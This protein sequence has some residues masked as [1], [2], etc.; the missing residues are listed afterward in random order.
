MKFWISLLFVFLLPVLLFAQN[1][2]LISEI[3]VDPTDQEFIEIFNPN[4]YSLALDN[5]YLSDYN[6]YY[7]IVE[8]T[9]TSVESDFLVRFPAGTTI[10]SAGVL[11][12]ATSGQNFSGTADFE[13]VD[14]SAVPNMD[15]LYVGPTASL[16]NR[17]MAIL[18]YWDGQSDLVQD[19]DYAM[20]GDFPS[21]F[22]DKSGVS[23]DG[24]DAGSDPSTYLND[25]PVN[26]QRPFN[27]A[28]FTG[29]SMERI[30]VTEDGEIFVNGNGI[31]GHNETSEPIDQNF[32]SQ[33]TPTPGTTTLEIPTGNGSGIA[34]VS[35]DS[36]KTDSTLALTFT[37]KGSVTEVVTDITLTVP[38]SW[39]T[40]GISLQL[41]GPAF[42]SASYQVT[43]QTVTISDAAL[44]V[45]DSGIITI[46]DLT[47][48]SQPELSAFEI[49]T[50]VSGGTLTPINQSPVVT[51]FAPAVFTSI[52]DIQANPGAYSTVTIEAVVVVG[53]GITATAWTDAY[54][55]DN[56]GAGINVYR[57]NEVDPDLVR[58]N[59]VRITG[60][61]TEYIAP[62]FTIPVTEIT[63]YTISVI[64]TGNPLP[65]AQ[66][67]S[68]SEANNT[69]LEGT[70]VAVEGEVTDFAQGIGGGTNIR[71]NDGSGE[72]LIRVWDSA[73]LNLT[74][75]SI[76]KQIQVK[77]PLDIYQ[78]A[79]QLLLAY[80][81]DLTIQQTQPGDGS[82]SA[83]VSPTQVGKGVSNIQLSFDLA[84]AA[85]YTLTSVSLTIP[86]DWQWS[87]NQNDVQVSGAAFA[88][89]TMD[90]QGKTILLSQTSLT[91]SSTGN[92]LVSNL[93]SPNSDKFS[94]FIIK[95]ATTGGVLTGISQSPR[96]QVGQGVVST[97]IS[98]IQLNTSQYVGQEVTLLA[99]VTLGAGITTTSWTDA[100]VQDNSGYGINVYQGGSV[101]TRI[102]R[103]H[104]LVITGTVDEYNGTT[105]ITNYTIETLSEN[106]PL[107]D[108]LK[109][110]TVE[111]SDIQ[112][113]GTYIEVSGVISD[114]YSAGGGTT[115][116]VDDGSGP[117][118]LRIW[119]SAGLNINAFAVGDTITARG[120]MDIYSGSGQLLIGYQ[121]DIFKP[122]T[123]VTGDGNG[124]A[125]VN[126]DTISPG[127][128]NV[129]LTFTIW[130]TD[131]DT[132]RTI[133]L[134]T[135]F[136]WNWSGLDG[137]VTISGS[138]F[139]GASKKVE[140]NYDE[141]RLTIS[142]SFITGQDT[143]Y[144]TITGFTSPSESVYSYFWF[145]TA[146]QGGTPQFIAS[147]PRIT[148]GDFPIYQIRDLQTNSTQFKTP[149]AIR[150][151][152]TVGSGV[153]RTDRTSAYIQDESGFGINISQSGA[154]DPVYQRAFYVRV[155]GSV[156]EY[157][158]T[159]QITPDSATVIDSSAALPTPVLVSTGDAN[160]PR[161]DGTLIRVP[162]K[163]YD[164]HA[165]VI[166]KYTTSTAAPFDY[167]IVVNDGTGDLTLRV[168]GT[169]GI[170]LD[171]VR[172]NEAIIATGV[173]SVF[174]TNEGPSY[175][176]LPAYQDDIEIDETFSPTL[177]GVF[178]KVD[179]HPFVPDRGETIRIRYNAGTVN[180]RVTIRVFDLA[181]RLV[182]TLLDETV[183]ISESAIEWDG[184]NQYLDYV[185]LG[186]YLCHLEVMEP[187]SGK[188]RNKVAPIVVGTI[189]KK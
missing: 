188:K 120:P 148:V 74:G 65:A 135:P 66:M 42:G 111:A 139:S 169:T 58:G 154:P 161:W 128:E 80:Q 142:N 123:G 12:V 184:R 84:G 91:P 116:S 145:K 16:S 160:N 98:D 35:P 81:S 112:W 124:F 108:P 149:V 141:Y 177:D 143:G 166:E 110:T 102:V 13:I 15:P 40:T 27:P 88:G 89:S 41:S 49:S 99:V 61:V 187:V 37:L 79:T 150:G 60:T 96:V 115:I 30:S 113:E 68:T 24:P 63:D 43:N 6:T 73:G 53:S 3:Q 75:V 103:G 174:I 36:V 130:G 107:P 44:T 19:V 18:F 54:V 104:Q 31:T 140:L 147:S 144:I 34:R 156:S 114:L 125:T 57:A 118:D 127:K 10:D 69:A 181:G 168:W 185:P 100:Y 158:E 175:Q 186:T 83:T 155:V 159:T 17:E 164:E 82:G 46:S 162:H 132:M 157:R 138:G 2:L 129:S 77:G 22:V 33:S 170:N 21:S 70:Y 173:G 28:P 134:I 32:A 183:R 87:G 176:I 171:S 86:A 50:A 8:G 121:Q 39:N 62:T 152:V 56:S 101:D 167:N 67:I 180:N 182:T 133:Q 48:P 76:G 71:V 78:D 38:G 189:L 136:N 131:A 165:V 23:I 5:Y 4:P 9:F 7:Q 14:N 64:S 90:I 137:D 146:V 55:Q 172:V 178:L 85:G 26:S 126:R 52:A 93:T 151:V 47:S 106:Y 11:V 97:P 153:L 72:C 117:C 20:W 59:R 25:T 105:E 92:I 51:V 94:S 163:P 122:G 95:T 109:L 29:S 45:S 119:D 1:H 179:P